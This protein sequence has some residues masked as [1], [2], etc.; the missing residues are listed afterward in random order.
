MNKLSM[1]TK[2]IELTAKWFTTVTNDLL[3][4]LNQEGQIEYI[5]P[6]FERAV[7]YSL[8]E[9]K[10]K[11]YLTLVHDQ[12]REHTLEHMELL[13]KDQFIPFINRHKRK[14]GTYYRL[15]WVMAA[16]SESGY[17]QA[18]ARPIE[19]SNNDGKAISARTWYNSFYD[20]SGEAAHM[21][22]LE[23]RVIAVNTAFEKLFGWTAE[24]MV[25]E[26][27]QIIP[28]DRQYEFDQA[29]E[30]VLNGSRIV[31]FQTFRM[32]KDGTVFPVSVTYSK[33]CDDEGKIV[34]LSAIVKDLTELV[35]TQK[36][37]EQQSEFMIEQEK[38]LHNI[39]DNINEIVGLY[40]IQMGKYLYISPSYER[41]WGSDL[42]ELYKDS[43]AIFDTIYAEDIHKARVFFQTPCDSAK[44]LEYRIVTNSGEVKWMRTKMTPV[45]DNDGTVIR[46]L[47]ISQDISTLKETEQ[48]IKKS[49]KLGVV[50]QLA[51]GIAHEIR[52]P[53][54][55]VKGFLQLLNQETKTKYADIILTELE[56]IEF[57][58]N[59]FLMLA[60]PHE[61]MKMEEKSV[62]DVLKEVITFM[63]PEAILN[64]V[65]IITEF[66]DKPLMVICEEKQLKQVFINLIK[67]AI[68]AI[69]SG[70]QIVVR[71]MIK[72]NGF[73]CIEVEDN[74]VGISKERV[75]R[76]GEPFYSSKE[77]GTGLGLMVS[78][79]I[80]ENH[81]GTVEISS[82]EGHGTTVK[83]L[84]PIVK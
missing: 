41:V 23:G 10:N 33:I 51:A 15:H 73:I 59:E 26:I 19:Y 34:A 7:Q 54:T 47:S 74:G 67:N 35:N 22:D 48:L 6:S 16:I 8:S 78:F 12:D 64:Q 66:T 11:S 3:L 52:N 77:K 84:L 1:N 18:V 17:T 63:S 43:N 42:Q 82:E 81:N 24:E 61:E 27:L 80:I 76:L 28:P 72:S 55:A 38:L 5:N 14:D 25:G 49:D 29:K 9:I 62:T 58:M 69:S 70:G 50:G 31:N 68:E 45:K 65:E 36:I 39:S 44:E 20:Y 83:I 60:K 57:I 79:K 56:R 13:K 2:E 75:E 46:H 53:L 21:F 37:L 30:Q 32:K 4:L 40:D 71:T